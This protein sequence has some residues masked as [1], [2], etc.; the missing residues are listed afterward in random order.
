MSLRVITT[1]SRPDYDRQI[2]HAPFTHLGSLYASLHHNTAMRPEDIAYNEFIARMNREATQED[3]ELLAFKPAKRSLP[4]SFYSEYSKQESHSQALPS[5]PSILSN[6]ALLNQRFQMD[7]LE[8]SNK[9]TESSSI[10]LRAECKKGRELLRSV[11]PQAIRKVEYL[12]RRLV[13]AHKLANVHL[14]KQ[15]AQ[16]L[17]SSQALWNYAVRRVIAKNSAIGPD[18]IDIS[19]LSWDEIWDLAKK[20]KRQGSRKRV[21]INRKIELGEEDRNKYDKRALAV[22]N[23]IDKVKEIVITFITHPYLFQ[24]ASPSSIGFRYGHDRI[25]GMQTFISQA[26]H[27]Y[28]QD[29]KIIDRDFKKCYDNVHHTTLR[30]LFKE[31]HLP[32]PAERFLKSTLTARI[33]GKDMQ[34]NYLRAKDQYPRIGT[35]QGNVTSP[36]NANHILHRVDV[37]LTQRQLPF[38]RYADNIFIAI[39]SNWNTEEFDTYLQSLLPK[40]MMLK[41]KELGKETM[42]NEMFRALGLDIQ[43]GQGIIEAILRY[44]PGQAPHESHPHKQT[45]DPYVIRIDRLIRAAYTMQAPPVYPVEAESR[46]RIDPTTKE[47]VRWFTRLRT[48]IP[49][50]VPPQPKARPLPNQFM[51]DIAFFL[52]TLKEYENSSI[53]TA[54]RKTVLNQLHFRRPMT[55]RFIQQLGRTS[56]EQYNTPIFNPKDLYPSNKLR[57]ILKKYHGDAESAKHVMIDMNDS[58]IFWQN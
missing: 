14:I 33:I 10:I 55:C 20:T 40:P 4:Q 57:N 12:H 41:A 35:P 44:A 47:E 13:A 16:L 21:W 17:W 27:R 51:D 54:L 3:E 15:Y 56:L 45:I 9:W 18:R 19:K 38:C 7:P 25:T 36:D 23:Q 37:A 46:P 32:Q 42:P 11:T 24:M 43:P 26:L 28:G 29:F 1:R 6:H 58:T 31:Y 8:Q 50:I 34:G 2:I 48:D 53:I 49:P 39:P 52:Q 30:S 22:P 5:V